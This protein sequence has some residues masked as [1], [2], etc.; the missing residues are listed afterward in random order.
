MEE[1]SQIHIGGNNKSDINLI[2]S[3]TQESITCIDWIEYK[4]K[5]FDIFL[6][7]YLWEQK[8][9]NRKNERINSILFINNVK[10]VHINN[11]PK[12]NIEFLILLSCVFSKKDKISFVFNKNMSIDIYG[13]NLLYVLKDVSQPWSGERMVNLTK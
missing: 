7:R 3:L 5:K 11:P 2:S 8:I 6:N 4:E 9:E 10:K 13:K 1:N 12:N